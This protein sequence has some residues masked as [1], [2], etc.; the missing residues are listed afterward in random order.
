VR[1]GLGVSALPEALEAH[2]PVSIDEVE[3]GPV[4]VAVGPPGP[5]IVV[6][7]HRVVD[8]VAPDRRL[9]LGA[10]ALAGEFGRVDADDDEAPVSVAFVPLDDVREGM[11]AVRAAEGPEVHDHDPSAKARERER[12]RVDPVLDALELGRVPALALRLGGGVRAREGGDRDQRREGR[13]GSCGSAHRETSGCP[14]RR[15]T[16][17]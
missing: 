2:P 10:P 7:G 1:L 15:Q 12:W 13:D 6:L 17:G 11:L 4:A 9:R 14:G 3:G 16:A 8:S 5:R